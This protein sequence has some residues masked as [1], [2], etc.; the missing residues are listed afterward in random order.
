MFNTIKAFLPPLFRSGWTLV[1]LVTLS[2]LLCS[3]HSPHLFL[4]WWLAFAGVVLIALSM[5]LGVCSSQRITRREQAL[6]WCSW[7]IFVGGIC[8][9]G[10]TNLF[11][12]SRQLFLM[13]VLGSLCGYLLSNWV[14]RKELIAWIR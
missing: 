12:P 1:A 9:F 13:Y 2:L 11:T 5:A 7:L 4:V 3:Q 6:Y 14:K 10:A 8:C